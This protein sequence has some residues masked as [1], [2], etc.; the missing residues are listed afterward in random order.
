M[1]GYGFLKA[2]YANPEVYA[3]VI[4][5]ISDLIDGKEAT[6]KTGTQENASRH[7]SAFTFEILARLN[8]KTMSNT[9]NPS[10]NEILKTE[11]KNIQ[12]RLELFYL[13]AQSAF[14]VANRYIKNPND[15]EIWD[16]IRKYKPSC[17]TMDTTFFEYASSYVYQKL[18]QIERYRFRAEEDTRKAFEKYI[19]EEDN[20]ENY[21]KLSKL[22]DRDIE[23]ITNA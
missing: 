10:N 5:G 12:N 22:I 23:I 20:E 3:L 11:T 16:E 15:M 21:Y 19:Y 8:L 1:E 13:S 4:R 6:D 7:A 18:K 9:V 14:N 2:A 17:A